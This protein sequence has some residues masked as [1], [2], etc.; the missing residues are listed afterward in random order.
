LLQNYR[1]QKINCYRK[2]EESNWIK[3]PTGTIMRK[4]ATITMKRE[5]ATVATYEE[6][7]Y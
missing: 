6:R 5:T 2:Y 1:N 7:N 3:L 4:N